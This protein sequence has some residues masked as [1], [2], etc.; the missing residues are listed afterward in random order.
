MSC[1]IMDVPVLFS[2]FE[3]ITLIANSYCAEKTRKTER[4]KGSNRLDESKKGGTGRDLRG[5]KKSRRKKLNPRKLQA[6]SYARKTG[7]AE[8]N[9]VSTVETEAHTPKERPVTKARARSQPG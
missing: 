1:L 6:G 3:G 4:K 2:D 5:I 9:K 8:Q 7:V